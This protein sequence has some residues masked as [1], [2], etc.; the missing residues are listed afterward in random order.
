MCLH[1]LTVNKLWV[2]D[3]GK[4]LLSVFMKIFRSVPSILELGVVNMN[5]V[6]VVERGSSISA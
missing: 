6:A 2:N 1:C 5:N 3:I 4:S